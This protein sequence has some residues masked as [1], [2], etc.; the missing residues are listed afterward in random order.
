LKKLSKK[1]KKKI[2]RMEYHP[3]RGKKADTQRRE[4]KVGSCGGKGCRLLH[5]NTY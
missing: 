1:R 5:R 2:K 3:G 4:E